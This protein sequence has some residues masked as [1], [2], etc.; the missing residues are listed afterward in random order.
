MPRGHHSATWSHP[1]CR[2]ITNGDASGTGVSLSITAVPLASSS[3]VL[4]L[5]CGGCGRSAAQLDASAVALLTTGCTSTVNG[6]PGAAPPLAVTR[7]AVLERR[8]M[9]VTSIRGVPH[10]P[11]GASD[12]PQSHPQLLRSLRRNLAA[13]PVPGAP[14][15]P[16][17]Y[18]CPRTVTGYVSRRRSVSCGAARST[19]LSS[20]VDKFAA[21][22]A[23][24]L[25]VT[26]TSCLTK[27]FSLLMI[28]APLSPTCASVSKKSNER[29]ASAS[30]GAPTSGVGNSRVY[31][32]S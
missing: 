19:I 15:A 27:A 22:A 31:T 23:R 12:T 18:S 4:R 3:R 30:P 28:S 2:S 25:S 8:A 10:T 26:S 14:P 7:V 5:S 1:T 11:G 13:A 21:L 29:M 20:L 16:G 24:R 6:S 32:Q 17:K 9:G